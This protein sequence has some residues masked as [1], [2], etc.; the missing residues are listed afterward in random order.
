MPI[1]LLLNKV[2][3]ITK[4][5]DA[6]SRALISV[7][8]V[9]SRISNNAD[10]PEDL[11]EVSLNNPT[12]E[13]NAITLPLVLPEGYPQIRKIEY[14]TMADRPLS[15]VKPRNALTSEGCALRGHY[16]RSG[17]SLILSVAQPGPLARIGYYRATPMLT[18]SDTHWL[19]E[20]QET[21]I[22]VGVAAD[23]FKA[24]GDDQSYADYQASF[25][26]LYSEFRRMR[27]DNEE[28]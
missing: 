5:P 16:Y 18:E 11:I 27:V 20:Q 22:I 10:Y 13:L 7:N 8:T 14:V 21:L 4:R 28:L 1:S 23:V 3:D 9:I 2:E 15:A 19:I 24:T 17:N 26:R 12:P 25:D 6:R